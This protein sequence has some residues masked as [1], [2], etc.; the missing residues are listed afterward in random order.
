[1]LISLA[2]TT[3]T[4][5]L[6]LASHRLERR[7]AGATWCRAPASVAVRGTMRRG[8]TYRWRGLDCAGIVSSRGGTP[9]TT[10]LTFPHAYR[11]TTFRL[12]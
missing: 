1:M 2:T 5:T 8:S 6:G 12:G 9:G 7:V 11:Y 4:T 10:A 3:T